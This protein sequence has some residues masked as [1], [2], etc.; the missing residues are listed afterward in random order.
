MSA[1]FFY[2]DRA[3]RLPCSFPDPGRKGQISSLLIRNKLPAPANIFPVRQHRELVR[4]PVVSES[5]SDRRFGRERTFEKNSLLREFGVTS[6]KGADP[7]GEPRQLG[8]SG[9]KPVMPSAIA[10]RLSSGGHAPTVSG[11]APV[12]N[13]PLA[14]SAELRHCPAPQGRGSGNFVTARRAPGNPSCD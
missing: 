2:W 13:A 1:A 11:P 7:L 8:G 10:K 4:Q 14:A 6:K 5:A 3:G 12:E 9:S